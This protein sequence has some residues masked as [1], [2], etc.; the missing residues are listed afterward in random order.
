M[1]QED[2]RRDDTP[3]ESSGSQ[4]G[5][6]TD[7]PVV[8]VSYEEMLELQDD[9]H[10]EE[11]SWGDLI[12]TQDTDGSTDNVYLAMDQ[13]LVYTPPDDPPVVPSD[14]LQNVEIAAGFASSIE[15]SG[16]DV[17]DLPERVDGNDSDLE[18]NIRDALRYN[19][20]TSHL[21]DVRVY[22]RNGIVYL[23]GTVVT[24]DD[25]SIVDEMVRDID[26]VSEVQNDLEV[27]E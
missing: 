19:S 14:D 5:D 12:D 7:P 21:D 11:T 27:A 25:I 6:P 26:E 18:T 22:V 16:L 24:E 3:R 1:A 23:K 15:E 20:E 4:W 13:G 10:S 8:E 2:P 17:E 9:L